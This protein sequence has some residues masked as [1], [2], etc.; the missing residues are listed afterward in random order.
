MLWELIL[1]SLSLLFYMW[2]DSVRRAPSVRFDASKCFL[3]I[4][5]HYFPVPVPSNA[6]MEGG[7]HAPG[8]SWVV[9]GALHSESHINSSNTAFSPKKSRLHGVHYIIWPLSPAGELK[10]R[11]GGRIRNE[12]NSRQCQRNCYCWK[13]EEKPTQGLS[14]QP[15]LCC[16]SFNSWLGRNFWEVTVRLSVA[17]KNYHQ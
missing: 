3:N 9:M 17:S 10:Q 15:L 8:S 16:Q 13:I 6:I 2:Y 1:W 5:Y 11:W 14:T 12:Q 4:H 7:H